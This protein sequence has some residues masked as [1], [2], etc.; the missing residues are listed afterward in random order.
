MIQECC[1]LTRQSAEHH[2]AA[3]LLPLQVKMTELKTKQ[4]LWVEIKNYLL[5]QK[6]KIKK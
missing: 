1:G 5:R 2:T 4:N 3:Y 6:K